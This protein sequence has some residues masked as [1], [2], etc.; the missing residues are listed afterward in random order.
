MVPAREGMAARARGWLASVRARC[1]VCGGLLGSK[2]YYFEEDAEL[3]DP[4]QAWTICA[5]C[6]DA[7][8]QQLDRVAVQTP[9]RLRVAVAVVASERAT[10][11]SLSARLPDPARDR[12][13][14]RRM[15]RLLIA[16]FLFLF[17]IHALVFIVIVAVISAH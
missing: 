9:M 10:P 13:A 2:A 12:L 5:A 3:P 8:L 1:D 4:R 14:D 16:L 7:V 11:D 6:N 15:E 17:I